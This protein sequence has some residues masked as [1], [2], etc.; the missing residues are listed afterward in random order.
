MA[1]W[2]TL[3]GSGAKQRQSA[4]PP[5]VRPF[6]RQAWKPRVA[7]EDGAPHDSKFS[8]TPWLRPNETWP[9]CQHCGK[10]MPLFLQLNL[11]TL[12]EE[13]DAEFGPGLLQLFYCASDAPSCESECEAFFP[14]TGGKLARIVQPEGASRSIEQPDNVRVFPAR[15]IIGWNADADYP[16]WEEGR[17]LGL[18]LRD[19]DWRQLADRDFPR[20]GDKLAGWPHWI[21]GVEY[22]AC[23]V[24]HQRMRLVFQLDSNDHIPYQ[25]GDLGCGHLTQCPAHKAQVAFGWACT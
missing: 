10:P 14:F 3:F 5:A 7:E 11:D 2:Q 1:W 12:P 15:R 20:S 25:F 17:S 8:G 16:N 6:K 23:P 24:C 9:A 19:M 18:D 21:Q 22:P 13:L 4:I